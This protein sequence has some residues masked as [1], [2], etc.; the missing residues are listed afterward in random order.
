[1]SNKIAIITANMGNF[2]KNIDPVE[3]SVKA[4]FFRFIDSNFPPR[5]QAMT[6]RFQARIP[7]MFGWQMAPGYDYY[8][9]VDSSCAI[10]NPDTVDW[11]MKQGSVTDLAV[12]KHPDRNTIQEEADFVKKKV[13]QKDRYL[14]SRYDNELID[15]EM[16]EIKADKDYVDDKL[17]ASTAFI[18]HNTPK[19]QAMMKEWWYHTSRYHIIDQLGFPYVLNKFKCTL[20]IIK[21]HY[22]HTPYLTYVR[23]K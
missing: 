22:M 16:A 6:S 2:D 13:G 10:E 3:Q 5:Y 4:D 21:E 15:E 7:K 20:N 14:L 19:V 8:I 23:N 18:Y 9:W 17:F 12:F 1:M 11:F